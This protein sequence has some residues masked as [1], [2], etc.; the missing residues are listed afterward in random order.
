MS[1]PSVSVEQLVAAEQARTERQRAALARFGRTLVSV[2]LVTP[3]PVKDGPLARR[4][5][6]EALYKLE[7]LLST[8]RWEVP[9]RDMRWLDTGPEA[10]YVV[11]ADAV[12]LKSATSALAERHASGRLWK[13]DVISAALTE[14]G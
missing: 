13:F 4:L 1:A 5:L 10:L 2:T 3:G 8:R 14:R 12:A 9:A 6:A 7:E 11:E